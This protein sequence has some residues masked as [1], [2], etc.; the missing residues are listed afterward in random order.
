MHMDPGILVAD[1]GHL[2][3]IPVK[4]G[5]LAIFLEEPFVGAGG[6][7]GHD[8]A[9]QV[10]L[11]DN[12]GHLDRRILGTGKKVIR[13]VNHRGQ[14][15]GIFHHPRH[16]NHASYI[17]PAVTDKNSRPGSDAA[18]ILFQ[19]Q[20]CFRNQAAAG[21]GQQFPGASGGAARFHHR[22]RYVLRAA[23]GAADKHSRPRSLHGI[24]Q[25][26]LAEAILIEVH[27]KASGKLARFRRRR[28]PYGQDDH[29]KL[30]LHEPA[31]LHDVSNH[32]VF[33]LLQF[34]HTGRDRADITDAVFFLC[35]VYKTV[36]IF[37][38]GPYIHEEDRRFQIVRVLLAHDRL[39]GGIHAAY[40]RA[41]TVAA[42]GIPRTDTLYEGNLFWLLSVGKP[43]DMAEIGAGSRKNPF[44]LDARN[45]VFVAAETVFAADAGI[46]NF[47]ARGG[48]YRAHFQPVF[49]KSF[50][51]PQSAGNADLN[52][53]VTFGTDPAIQAAAGF[54][55]GIFF[56][57]AYG[58]LLKIHFSFP[59]LAHGH[60]QS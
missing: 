17:Y 49:L 36:E 5:F 51:M 29:V 33:R 27:A 21:P 1:I 4:T 59:D 15:F 2:K 60:R 58:N 45:D 18:Q 22:F 52:A 57:E 26:G 34:L 23:E 25:A 16:V 48:D 41:P 19:G 43:L 54:A 14:G 12:I 11:P 40:G 28:E 30:F 44:K 50:F 7:G 24:F 8:D 31:V 37:A 42:G 39:F 35:P 3:K 10:L 32:E 38:V 20:L 9:R 46:K 53:L 55:P 6:T 47:K 13:G 56:R